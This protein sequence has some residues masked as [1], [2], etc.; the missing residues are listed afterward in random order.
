M[1]PHLAED[2]G[3]LAGLVFVPQAEIVVDRVQKEVGRVGVHRAGSLDRIE[4]DTGVDIGEGVEQ[5]EGL[6]RP[7]DQRESRFSP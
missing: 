7:V 4:R 1:I 5:R 6:A 3:E 2:Q